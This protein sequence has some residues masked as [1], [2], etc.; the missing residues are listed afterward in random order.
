MRSRPREG[1][2]GV[3]GFEVVVVP[4][5]RSAPSS[6][7]RPSKTGVNALMGRGG[8]RSLDRFEPPHPNPLPPGE[9]EH[10]EFASRSLTPA[11]VAGSPLSRGRSGESTNVTFDTPDKRTWTARS[12]RYV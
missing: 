3:T 6:P 12:A 5:A 11:R 10:T 2:I 1:W 9:R 8:L 4:R 7:Q